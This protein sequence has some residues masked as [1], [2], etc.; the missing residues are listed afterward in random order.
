MVSAKEASA[1]SAIFT[2]GSVKIHPGGAGF[3]DGEDPPQ[4]AATRAAANATNAGRTGNLRGTGS[5][6]GL[7]FAPGSA[8]RGYG[9]EPRRR[10]DIR[11]GPWPVR[12]EGRRVGQ[13]PPP[14]RAAD[15]L[16]TAPP[17]RP[18]GDADHDRQ[19]RSEPRRRRDRHRLRHGRP[20]HRRPAGPP[21]RPQ[22]A[23]ARAPLPG[24]R[25]HPHLHP[26][27]R[28]RV[29]RGRPLRRRDGP[30]GHD[31]ERACRWPPAAASAGRR[32]PR[33][34]TGSSSRA[35]SSASAPG[36]R[37][38]GTT[39]SPPSRP[40]AAPSTGTSTT[41]TGPRPGWASWG[42]AP[43]LRRR[44]PLSRGRCSPDGGASRSAPPA[45][46]STSTSGTSG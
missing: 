20:R 6:I 46:G 17:R 8:N 32:C 2:T 34:T 35:S 27:R 28:V 4:P 42:C 13:S 24:G 15:S 38:S 29:G 25:L 33:P 23:G 40:S 39:S 7:S 10:R 18:P 21:P 3:G 36:S 26:P 44:W 16:P 31:A 5:R 22:G 14:P 30:A 45:P 43:A 1:V 37:T 11:G 19:P 9:G 41:W 12:P